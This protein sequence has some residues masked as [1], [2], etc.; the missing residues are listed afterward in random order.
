L[1]PP[2]VQIAIAQGD[3]VMASAALAELEDLGLRFDTPVVRAVLE[4]SRGRVA[5]ALG[6]PAT[7]EAAL[8]RALEQWTRLTNPYEVA[9]VWTLIG[10][11]RRER[12]DDSGSAEAF[13]TAVEL[14]DA[15]GAAAGLPQAAG[16]AAPERPRPAGLTAREIEVLEL[17]AE[18]LSN[19]GIAERLFLSQK[20]VSRH[21]SNIYTK[22]DVNSRAA[23]T[24]FAFEHGIAG[25]DRG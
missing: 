18:G 10:E 15:I 6:D 7:A 20:T 24:A 22:I 25:S 4:M 12:G 11:A 2:T 13:T 16:T 17:V 9:T 3:L 14:F 21:L 19:K 23:A 1:L 8:T 5:L